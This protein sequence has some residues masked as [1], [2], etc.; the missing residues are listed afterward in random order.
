MCT[1]CEKVPQINAFRQQVLRHAEKKLKDRN[2]AKV[3]DIALTTKQKSLRLKRLRVKYRSRGME[4]RRLKM[5]LIRSSAKL[6]NIAEM[7]TEHAL[8]VDTKALSKTLKIAYDK[9]MLS[10]KENTV[11]FV[12]NLIDNMNKKP[13]GKIY[14]SFTKSMYEVVKI[15][16]GERLVKFLSINLD[17]PD[18]RTVR[19]E[20]QKNISACQPGFQDLHLS[21]LKTMYRNLMAQY[22]IKSVLVEQAEDE[23]AIIKHLTYNNKNG[24]YC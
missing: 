21:K 8:Q 13:K 11:Q 1:A 16:G 4:I 14:S 24:H 15:W 2:S 7:G 22:N 12:R 6:K 17:G 19:Q 18:A 5:R 9:G 20:V 23:T 10:D 3:R